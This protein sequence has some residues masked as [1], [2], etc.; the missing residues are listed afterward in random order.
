VRALV[1]AALLAY[2]PGAGSMIRRAAARSLSLGRTREV[3]LT[4]TFHDTADH[5]AQLV[6]HFPLSCRLE[7]EGGLSFSVKGT[8]PR[9]AGVAEGAAGPGL[10]LLQLACPLLATRGLKPDEAEAAWTNAVQSAGVDLNA[11]GSLVRVG[12]RVAVVLGGAG[13]PQLWL[14]QD[15]HAPA[16]LVA[17]GGVELRL[18][19]YGN[20]AAAEWFPRVLELWQGGQ[21]AARFEALEVKGARGASEDDDDN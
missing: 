4:G 11:P 2:V 10:Q 17:Q 5:G 9:P 19:E 16:R 18:L 12:D 21:L 7:G 6:L 1:L 20:P 15:T 14:Y 3:T 13:K 8:V